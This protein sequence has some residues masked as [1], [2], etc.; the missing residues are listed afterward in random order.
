MIGIATII[1]LAISGGVIIAERVNTITSDILRYLRIRLGL[2]RPILV[3][4]YTNMGNSKIKPA[5]STDA[6][7][8]A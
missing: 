4:K 7:T 5:D 2:I 1:W 3:R 8:R 6:R